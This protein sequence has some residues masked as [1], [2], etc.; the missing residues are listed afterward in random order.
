MR[1]N[2][3]AHP[4]RCGQIVQGPPVGRQAVLSR[5]T[6]RQSAAAGVLESLE[7]QTGDQKAADGSW[8]PATP[9]HGMQAH[10][11]QACASA[12]GIAPD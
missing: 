3:A 7:Q 6:T 12:M 5:H 2:D 4:Q 1:V 10:P 11:A 8:P 9:L